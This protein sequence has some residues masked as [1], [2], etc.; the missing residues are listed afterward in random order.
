[1]EVRTD[2]LAQ[3]RGCCASHHGLHLVPR[4][5]IL[6]AFLSILTYLSACHQ[7]RVS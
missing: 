3:V 1:M 6:R 5:R 7:G 2:L 4:A